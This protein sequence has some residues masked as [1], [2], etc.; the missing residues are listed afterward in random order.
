M[1][2]T[3]DVGVNFIPPGITHHDSIYLIGSCFTEHI[4]N[5]LLEA[6]FT[7]KYNVYGIIYNPVSIRHTLSELLENKQYSTEE[8]FFHQGLW[9]SFNHHGSFSGTNPVSV[10]QRINETINEHREFLVKAKHIFITPGTS[11]LYRKK[12]SAQ[13]VANCHKVPGY[14]FEKVLMDAEEEAKHWLELIQKLYLYSPQ[15]TIHFTISPVKHLR[16]GFFENNLSKG[17]LHQLIYKIMQ[18]NK[19]IR[20]FPS[21]EI[22]Q[23]ELRDYRFYDRDLTHPNALAIDIIWE[24]FKLAYFAKPTQEIIDEVMEIRK[25]NEH[26]ILHATEESKKF[27]SYRIKRMED[28]QKK[29]PFIKIVSKQ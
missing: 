19:S 29:Y 2:L 14:E 10:C 20:Y 1:K 26:K 3:S 7:V 28:L 12:S 11:W 6:G 24:K 4:A 17:L 22:M 13:V 9:H 8:L 5:K 23:D 18:Q 16:D 21:F 27:E 15:L 25:L